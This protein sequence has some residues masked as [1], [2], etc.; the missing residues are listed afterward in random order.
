MA[1][2]NWFVFVTGVAT[3]ALMVLRTRT[4]EANLLARFGDSY[5]GYM[6]RTGRF[7]PRI[8]R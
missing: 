6:A 2:A 7:V 5:R 8:G 3:L 1:A 4:E